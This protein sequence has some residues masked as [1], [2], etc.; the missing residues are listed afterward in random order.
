MEKS[1]KE[2]TLFINGCPAF[3]HSLLELN[4]IMIIYKAENK[5][6]EEIKQMELKKDFKDFDKILYNFEDMHEVALFKLI[7]E[8]I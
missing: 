2:P 5:T 6:P 3:Y 8:K 7:S 4:S 1:L